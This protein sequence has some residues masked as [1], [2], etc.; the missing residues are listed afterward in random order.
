MDLKEFTNELYELKKQKAK[1]Y[2]GMSI[3][4]YM[5]NIENNYTHSAI[6]PFI[7]F[8]EESSELQQLLCKIA[9]DEL[10][11]ILQV[12]EELADCYILSQILTDYC[13]YGHYEVF[14]AAS[15]IIPYKIISNLDLPIYYANETKM[16]FNEMKVIV[17]HEATRISKSRLIGYI[18]ALN[19]IFNYLNLD[20][21]TLLYAVD[22]K[23]NRFIRCNN[24]E[25]KISNK[26]D[27]KCL[28]LM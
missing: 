7:F 4:R 10:E 1:H 11:D 22:V 19:N 27:G 12:Y 16:L 13:G 14:Y 18:A 15:T 6:G 23:L 25:D 5:V 8:I 28:I 2:T 9:R 26:E 21:E 17:D 20:K 24:L 3:Y